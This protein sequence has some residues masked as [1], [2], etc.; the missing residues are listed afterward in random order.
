MLPWCFVASAD[1]FDL[2][3]LNKVTDIADAMI[4]HRLFDELFS[5]GIVLVATSNRGK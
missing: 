5:R 4:L 1:L 3:R 2:L